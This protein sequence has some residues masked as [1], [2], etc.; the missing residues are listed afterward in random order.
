MNKLEELW[1][2]YEPFIASY[3]MWIIIAVAVVAILVIS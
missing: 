3:K 1:L 2:K